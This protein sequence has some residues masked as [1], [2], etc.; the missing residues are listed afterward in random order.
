[1]SENNDELEKQSHYATIRGSS[2]AKWSI[3]FAIVG[4]AIA[5]IAFAWDVQSDVRASNDTIQISADN[6]NATTSSDNADSS[7]TGNDDFRSSQS[8][9]MLIIWAVVAAF[10]SLC[11]S[12]A[13]QDWLYPFWPVVFFWLPLIVFLIVFW[14]SL[15]WWGIIVVAM[16]WLLLTLAAGEHFIW[17]I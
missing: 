8:W 11:F 9:W 1:M 13:T 16:T 14:P 2:Y 5:L 7:G 3:V 4:I 10:I 6:P 12:L 15:A 17:W